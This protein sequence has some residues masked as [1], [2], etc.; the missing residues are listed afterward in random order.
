MP[1]AATGRWQFL[2]TFGPLLALL[3]VYAFFALLNDRITSLSALETMVQQTV[4]VGVA[5]IGM[6]LVIISGGIDLSSGSLIAFSSVVI[7]QAMVAHGLSPG[8][9]ALAGI[10]AATLCGWCNGFL[11]TRLKLVPFIVTLGTLLIVRGLAKGIANSMQ[12]NAGQSWLSNLLAVLPPERKWQLVPPG[13]WFMIVLALVAAALLRYT[14]LGRH[15]FAIGS[16][17]RT[18]QL[19][20]IAVARVKVIVYAIA[21]ACAGLSG[22][23]LLSYQEQGDPTAA[24]GLELDII[25]AVVIGGGSLSGGEGAIAGSLIGAIIMTIIRTG[26]QL[27][28]WAP[29]ITQAVTGCVIVIAVAVDRLR[30]RAAN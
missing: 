7:A 12:I 19:C 18:A 3:L 28:G 21:G 1:A 5:A 14:R 22:L 27:N 13:A 9:A 10:A 2:N 23:M 4:I 24:V 15:I 26:C 8:V 6:T 16:N 11:I 17:E 30:H 25:A 20:G 29:W